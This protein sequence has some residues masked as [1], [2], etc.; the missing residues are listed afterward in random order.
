MTPD[1]N[2]I[3]EVLRHALPSASKEQ[4]EGARER[5]YNRVVRQAAVC[6]S[7]EPV[8]DFGSA[9]FPWRRSVQL[10]AAAVFVAAAIWAGLA[11]Q[12]RRTLAVRAGERIYAGEIV[13]S[14]GGGG[15]VLKLRDGSS[16]EMRSKSELSLER[17]GDGIRIHLRS[18]GLIVKAARQ[19]A[20]HH[21]YVQT[22]DVTVSVVGT[23]FF[24][25]AE[26]EGSRVA[27]I[28]G[29]VRVQQGTTTKSLL[30]G[31]QLSTSPKL[32]PLAVKE[33]VSWSREAEAHVA[34]LQ[35]AAA[36]PSQPRL[37]F[38]VASIRPNSGSQTPGTRGGGS[39]GGCGG[40]GPAQIDP[41][42]FAIRNITLY[43]LIVKAYGVWSQPVG[44]CAG[45]FV[46]NL[47]SGGPDWVRSEHWD[48]QAN[49]PAGVP[50]YTWLHWET[51]KAPELQEML[52]NLLKDRFKLVLQ[53]E[54]K[55]MPVYLLTVSKPSPKFTPSTG[56]GNRIRGNSVTRPGSIGS[57]VGTDQNGQAYFRFDAYK[58]SMA[59]VASALSMFLSDPNRP[60]LDRT[61]LTGEFDIEEVQYSLGAGML[62]MMTREL[63]GPF[64]AAPRPS[65][66]KALEE[67]LGL[68][69]ED[70]REKIEVLSIKSAERPSD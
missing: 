56:V 18:G 49:I 58:V 68:K 42:R 47:L 45:V 23:V 10:A 37:V 39:G 11:W 51:A 31:Q 22:K 43:H 4:R 70:S 57:M 46:N 14:N 25:N 65:L 33:E 32:E 64:T 35:Q 54:A 52:R 67:E 29:E 36:V 1:K 40:P 50:S 38:E 66:A 59:Q 53:H 13:R 30:P 24:V 15:G 17:A 69:L 12:A 20:G 48:I 28:E 63:G 41:Q 27:V 62:G 6:D 44:G 2:N 55:E 61:G 7:A 3:E 26:E 8:A 21:L 19:V 5:I 60:V 34:L 16:V 9:R